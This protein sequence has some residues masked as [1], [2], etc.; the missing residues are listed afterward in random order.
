MDQE[1]SEFRR[2]ETLRKEL[3]ELE[4]RVEN[5]TYQSENNELNLGNSMTCKLQD[6]V[7]IDDGARYSDAAGSFQ[8][9]RV[10]KKENIIEKS[11]GK[12]KE[13]GTVCFILEVV[14]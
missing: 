6:L 2:F 8:L 3:M 11:L 7:V 9:S 13:T 14:L 12:L 1:S 5:S 10:Q 4:K